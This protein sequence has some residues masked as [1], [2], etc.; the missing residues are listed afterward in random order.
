MVWKA[1]EQQ[2]AVPTAVYYRRGASGCWPVL[3]R[4]ESCH[5]LLQLIANVCEEHSMLHNRTE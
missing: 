5:Y 1:T 3:E 2:R 4:G